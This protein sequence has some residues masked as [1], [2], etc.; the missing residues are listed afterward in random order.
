MLGDFVEAL[1]QMLE[2]DLGEFIQ[3]TK[4]SGADKERSRELDRF[5]YQPVESRHRFDLDF[6]DLRGVFGWY[7]YL[8]DFHPKIG[9]DHVHQLKRRVL[10]LAYEL[11][12]HVEHSVKL[13]YLIA[14]K[15]L[16]LGEQMAGHLNYQLLG[17]W[18]HYCNHSFDVGSDLVLELCHFVEARNLE[19]LD[20]LVE[21]KI[22]IGLLLRSHH[23]V[24][25]AFGE[26]N[27]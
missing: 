8:F 7:R 15:V 17:I 24:V 21:D 14:L 6:F 5:L 12:D 25:V 10:A 1:L 22:E 20:D 11:E 26:L 2:R 18:A 13:L 3:T 9:K 19:K 27:Q 23:L 4:V 16:H